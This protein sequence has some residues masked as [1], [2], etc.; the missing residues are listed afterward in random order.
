MCGFGY[1][2]DVVDVLVC[3]E[4]FGV[5]YGNDFGVFVVFIG[6][7]YYVYWLIGDY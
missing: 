2:Y 1:V 5:G 6:Y 4:Y 3:G 7:V